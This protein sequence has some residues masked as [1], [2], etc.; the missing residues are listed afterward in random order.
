MK[1]FLSILCL[2]LTF[3][4]N[5][6]AFTCYDGFELDTDM[7]GR[8]ICRYSPNNQYGLTD[9]PI[10]N[11][12][13]SDVDMYWDMAAQKCVACHPTDYRCE[14]NAYYEDGTTLTRTKK[15]CGEEFYGCRTCNRKG[16]TECSSGYTL[17]TYGKCV[18]DCP[19]NCS[20]CSSSSTCTACDYGYTLQNGQCVK[21]VACP[22][23]CAQCDSSGSCTKCNSGYKLKNGA[24]EAGS[25]IS[26]PDDMKLSADGCCCIAG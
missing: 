20:S 14:V 24:C 22:A 10:C 16:C 25:V 17:T 7:Y 5:A 11:T 19:T 13:D 9:Y 2:S 23:N 12:V 18:L 3:A 6:Q 26:C 8:E 1:K 4:A 21:K 15:G